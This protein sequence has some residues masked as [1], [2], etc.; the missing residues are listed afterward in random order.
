MV[1]VMSERVVSM[2]SRSV[3]SIILNRHVRQLRVWGIVIVQMLHDKL[4][5]QKKLLLV[6]DR[7]VAEVDR[8]GGLLVLV[9]TEYSKQVKNVML[10]VPLGVSHVSSISGPIQVTILLHHSR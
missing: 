7:V 8:Q 3:L 2:D 5:V 6:V 1:R 9:V 10:S 4:D